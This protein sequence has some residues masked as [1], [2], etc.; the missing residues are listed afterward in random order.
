MTILKSF[1]F[2]NGW[3]SLKI[4]HFFRLILNIVFFCQFDNHFNFVKF[5]TFEGQ[6]RWY[7]PDQ[8]IKGVH[9]KKRFWQFTS[10]PNSKQKTLSLSFFLSLSLSLSLSFSLSL[11]LSPLSLSSL[12]CS[13]KKFRFYWKLKW[14][15]IYNLD[16]NENNTP[17][18]NIFF[19]I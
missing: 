2:G 9:D 17:N 5:E 4:F 19:S 12:S 16:L 13:I 6:N 8:S 15:P 10:N 3:K 11:T 18:Q 7:I 14:F 1:Y